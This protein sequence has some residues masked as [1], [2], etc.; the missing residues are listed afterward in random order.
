MSRFRS[1]K[2]RL[3]D[4]LERPDWRECLEREAD[5]GMAPVGPLLALLARPEKREKAALGLGSVVAALAEKDP[6]AARVVMRRL[7][8]SLNEESGNLG[9][10]VP[11]AMGC[12]LARSP[13]LAGE[14]VRVFFSY[15][16]DTGRGEDNYLDYAPLRA[17]VFW[18]A[19][20]LAEA[21]PDLMAPYR[22]ILLEGTRDE[23][24]EVRQAAGLALAA[25]EA[26]HS[27]APSADGP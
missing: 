16:H 13:L 19:A 6:E 8:W 18:G 20:R 11:E 7:M 17:G 14:Y 21:R 25:L 27:G 4:L 23:H 9:W 1:D 15:V 3:S 5:G 24:A 26:R 12:I 22:S 10:G 2:V